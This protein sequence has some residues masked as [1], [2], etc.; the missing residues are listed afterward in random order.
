MPQPLSKAHP[1]ANV[2]LRTDLALNHRPHL[3]VLAIRSIAAYS[4]VEQTLMLLFVEL[5]GGSSADAA[6]IYL[7]MDTAKAKA[8]AIR[9]LSERKLSTTHQSFLNSILK[10]AK[11]KEKERN[12]IAHWT[13]S[14]SP[15]IS[16]GLLLI[17]PRTTASGNDSEDCIFVYK[18]R[19]FVDLIDG[20][21]QICGFGATMKLIISKHDPYGKAQDDLYNKLCRLP[22][23]AKILHPST[24]QD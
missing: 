14:I 6:A 10:L 2:I 22:A 21:N 3:A 8:N 5:A 11:S 23:V 24:R 20:C 16:D 18:E 7:A 9:V 17:D 1:R 4:H 12:K 13:W 15:E 19:D